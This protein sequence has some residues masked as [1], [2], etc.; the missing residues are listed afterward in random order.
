MPITKKKGFTLIELLIVIVIIGIL[1]S[2]AIVAFNAAQKKGRDVKRKS[3][4]DT[5]KKALAFYKGD[6]KSSAYYPKE[7]ATTDCDNT[8]STACVPKTALI[9]TGSPPYT[10]V[11]KIPKDPSSKTDYYYKAYLTDGS[12]DC[13]QAS[14]YTPATTSTCVNY[15]LIACLENT[16]DPQKDATSDPVC[17]AGTASYTMANE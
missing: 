12:S 9:Y 16:S 8:A 6:T 4:I 2:I 11:K 7:A 3:D 15:K 5:L 1:A 14:P 10:Y 13:A 17:P